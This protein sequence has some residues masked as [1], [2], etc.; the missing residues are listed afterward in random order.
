MAFKCMDEYGYGDYYSLPF[1][2]RE[3]LFTI[4]ESYVQERP[5]AFNVVAI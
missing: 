1:R 2:E 3:T 4:G 5:R